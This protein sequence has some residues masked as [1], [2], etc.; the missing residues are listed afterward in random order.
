MRLSLDEGRAG[1][2]RRGAEVLKN[3][4]RPVEEH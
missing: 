1:G 4:Q 2:G 3:I